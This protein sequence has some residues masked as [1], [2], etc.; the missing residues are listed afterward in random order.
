MTE[1]QGQTM[2]ATINI[3]RWIHNNNLT[4]SRSDPM[5]QPYLTGPELS[6]QAEALSSRRISLVAVASDEKSEGR[7]EHGQIRLRPPRHSLSMQLHCEAD[8]QE[9][10]VKGT[11]CVN[12]DAALAYLN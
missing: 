10:R 6:R 8:E 4:T 12:Y 2:K 5:S 11:P 7:C 9:Q 3:N 1:T